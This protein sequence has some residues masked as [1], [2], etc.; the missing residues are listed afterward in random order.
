LIKVDDRNSHDFT[1]TTPE[2][3]LVYEDN[4]CAVISTEWMDSYSDAVMV[5]TNNDHFN[6]VVFK[7]G[8]AYTDPQKSLDFTQAF[9]YNSHAEDDREYL[10]ILDVC[11]DYNADF[12]IISGLYDVK[13]YNNYDGKGNNGFVITQ[14]S[15]RLVY[16]E[17]LFDYPDVLNQDCYTTIF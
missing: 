11:P 9:T 6:R 13:E 4:S 14:G 1:F 7:D 12:G 10:E 8:I 15:L 2:F 16:L 3:E 17:D 5:N